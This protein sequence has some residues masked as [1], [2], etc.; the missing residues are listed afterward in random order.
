[1]N[2]YLL[3]AALL[4]CASAQAAETYVIVRVV[5]A[6]EDSRDGECHGTGAVIDERRGLI[7]TCWHTFQTARQRFGGYTPH[8]D[9]YGAHIP[10]YRRVPAEIVAYD[11]RADVAVLRVS[12]DEVD[13]AGT[14][15]PCGHQPKRGATVFTWGAGDTGAPTWQKHRLVGSAGGFLLTS[16]EQAHGRS[17]GPLTDGETGWIIGIV[18]MS[19]DKA[20]QGLSVPIKEICRVVQTCRAW[21]PPLYVWTASWCGPCKRFWQDYRT[22]PEFASA[23]G[24]RFQVIAVDYDKHPLGRALYGIRTVPTFILWGG[25]RIEGYQGQD[26]LAQRL[27]LAWEPVPEEPPKRE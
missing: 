2:F 7:L 3:C 9:I 15:A 6:A 24:E 13:A 17:G 21:R 26:D 8:V 16:G 10:K 5:A 25:G 4:W 1:M 18:T 27:N 14:L 22:D 19:D 12:P 20:H 23:L 11:A